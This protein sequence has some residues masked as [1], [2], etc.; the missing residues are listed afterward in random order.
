MWLF[1][2]KLTLEATMVESNI[3]LPVPETPDEIIYAVDTKS[4]IIFVG[5]GVSNIAGLPNWKTLANNLFEKCKDLAYLDNQQYD[6]TKSKVTDSKQLITIAFELFKK[7]ENIDGFNKEM[8]QLLSL[9]DGNVKPAARHIFDFCKFT[10]ATVLTTNADLLL[11]ECF[12]QNLIYDDIAGRAWEVTGTSLVKL[13]GTISKPETLVFTSSQY[14]TRYS[15]KKFK[16]FLQSIFSQG[17]TILFIGYGLG[18]FELLEYMLSPFGSETDNA[19]SKMYVLKP[20]FS[21][22]EPYKDNMDLYFGNMHIKQIAYS[23]DKNGYAQLAEVLK[24]WKADI[25]SKSNL[26]T[27]RF[28]QLVD[29]VKVGSTDNHTIAT[30]L[31]IISESLTAERYF[32][33]LMRKDEQ[34][35]KWIVALKSS[36]LFDPVYKLHP[37]K[38]EKTKDNK[39]VLR[40]EEWPGLQFVFEYLTSES[41]KETAPEV[42]E[43]IKGFVINIVSDFCSNKEKTTNYHAVILCAHMLFSFDSN[44]CGSNLFSFLGL[45]ADNDYNDFG[46]A[47]YG[48]ISPTSQFESWDVEDKYGIIKIVVEHLINDSNSREDYCFDEITKKYMRS[49]CNEMPAK[50]LS[51]MLDQ[52]I[53]VERKHR[54]AFAGVGSVFC[55]NGKEDYYEMKNDLILWC[56]SCIEAAKG[57]N[58]EEIKTKFTNIN[59]TKTVEKIYI[60]F[61][62]TCFAEMKDVFFSQ[63]SNPFDYSH[64]YADLYYL[65]E[66]NNKSISKKDCTKLL[67]WIDTS[68]F[69]YDPSSEYVK[70][71]KYDLLLLLSKDHPFVDASIYYTEDHDT[72][73]S[74]DDRSKDMR[75]YEKYGCDNEE[76]IE[77]LDGMSL[78]GII[79][80]LCDIKPSNRHDLDDYTNALRMDIKK[81]PGV[82]FGNLLKLSNLPIEY[83]QDIILSINENATNKDLPEII[84]FYRVVSDKVQQTNME[85]SYIIRQTIDSLDKLAVSKELADSYR[86]VYAFTTEVLTK[87]QETFTSIKI[88]EEDY[89]DIIGAVINIWYCVA[90]SMRIRIANLIKDEKIS[91]DTID[92]VDSLINSNTVNSSLIQE[93]LAKDLDLLYGINDAW[94]KLKLEYI[95]SNDDSLKTFLYSG[96]CTKEIYSLLDMKGVFCRFLDRYANETDREYDV[97]CEQIVKWMIIAAVSYE[98]PLNDK[99]FEP[100]IIRSHRFLAAI[101]SRV[102]CFLSNHTEY[103]G[104][105]K[106][107]LV[108]ICS[109]VSREDLDEVEDYDFAIGHL[110]GCMLKMNEIPTELWTCLTHLSQ[111]FKNHVYPEYKALL[112]KYYDTETDTIIE[113]IH[114]SISSSDVWT[115]GYAKD[116]DDLINKI[117]EDPNRN[118]TFN[119][120]NNALIAKGITRFS[121]EILE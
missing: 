112:E 100:S 50:V 79:Q 83:Y 12:E 76:I 84:D 65:I 109:K 117:K 94:A 14:L 15:N 16:Q 99:L 40:T 66:K 9:E 57:D 34:A 73:P 113:I 119:E 38:E 91:Q 97:M 31:Q 55:F 21:Y 80:F 60:F 107:V 26:N 46:S 96:F 93:T 90:I 51:F 54:F 108:E 105:T 58:I 1:A 4:L 49:V 74:I 56:K 63:E 13:H 10:N 42:Q 6:I 104:K 110:C 44:I 28:A 69:G 47:L 3:I 78:D 85:K 25:N 88:N 98:E 118:T 2:T 89:Y 52:I 7:N 30:V 59:K 61:I 92:F 106:D 36:T 23:K 39:T 75:V 29:L 18:E 48:I 11:D 5:A 95:F 33:N 120:I 62:S 19:A 121:E 115:F 64:L 71:L 68:D 70:S 37:A 82:Y 8:A 45:I 32:F 20:Y 17:N 87:T 77:E 53:N 111:R 114:N 27:Q 67:K 41:P 72:N 43:V 22:E 101:F 24:Q 102:E 103:Y 86:A 116:F 35:G 81:R